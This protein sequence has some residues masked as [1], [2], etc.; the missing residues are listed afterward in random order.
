MI[1]VE[2]NAEELRR[3]DVTMIPKFRVWD[4]NLKILKPAAYIDWQKQIVAY[5]I[6]D[7]AVAANP[8]KKITLMKSSGLKD[9]NGEEIYEGDIL[10]S[11]AS[12]NQE[13]W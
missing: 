1:R 2:K 13:D 7:F 10:L 12:E 8:F 4:K 5:Y 11:T 6:G 3:K 9:K